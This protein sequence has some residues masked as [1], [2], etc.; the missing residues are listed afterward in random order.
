MWLP[1]RRLAAST[2]DQTRNSERLDMAGL[3]MGMDMGQA[4][5]RPVG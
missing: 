4:Y 1:Y 5:K 3:S 2:P